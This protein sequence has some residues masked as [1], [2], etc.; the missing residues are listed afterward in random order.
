MKLTHH[1]IYSNFFVTK[2]LAIATTDKKTI[3]Q[4]ENN[5]TIKA[6]NFL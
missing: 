1:C 6:Q 4:M 2:L 5:G 3:M